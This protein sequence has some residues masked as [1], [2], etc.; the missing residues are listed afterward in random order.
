[1]DQ[2][3]IDLPRVENHSVVPTRQESAIPTVAFDVER[4]EIVV[5]ELTQAQARLAREA[6]VPASIEELV[7]EVASAVVRLGDDQIASVDPYLIIAL[8]RAVIAAQNALDSS[9]PADARKQLRVSL[10]QI[11]HAFRDIAEGEPVSEGR[12][13]EEL[14]RW[15]AEVTDVPQHRL[16]EL[17]GVP[18]RTWQRWVSTT[19]PTAPTGDHARTLRLVARIANHLRHALTGPGVVNWFDRPRADLRGASPRQLLD[20]PEAAARLTTLASGV[21]SSSAT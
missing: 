20:D 16:A 11:R 8:Q 2:L 4:P 18:D 1:L 9:D 6:E 10:E 3:T 15:L 21:R 12:P 14:A 17:I 7:R 19:D 5:Q 13:A